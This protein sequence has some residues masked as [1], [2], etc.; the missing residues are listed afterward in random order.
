M[1]SASSKPRIIC[2]NTAFR[3][4]GVIGVIQIRRG[5]DGSTYDLPRTVRKGTPTEPAL[6][7]P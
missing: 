3:K 5:C 4:K 7:K 6:D 2:G 1:V